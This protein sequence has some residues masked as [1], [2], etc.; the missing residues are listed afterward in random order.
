MLFNGLLHIMLWEGWVRHD[1][2]AAHTSGFDDLKATVRDC[3][4]DLVAQVCGIKKGRP[5]PRGK[6][7]SPL[8]PP[9]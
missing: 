1:Y 7:H 2:I 8:Q 5:V 6:D 3:T 4:P 9:P